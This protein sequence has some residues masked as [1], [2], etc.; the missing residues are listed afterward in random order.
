MLAIKCVA[1]RKWI[2]TCKP[3]KG[4]L[5][6]VT[7][8]QLAPNTR[9]VD[10]WWRDAGCSVSSTILTSNA[11]ARAPYTCITATG[12]VV[13]NFPGPLKFVPPV[14]SEADLDGRESE[15]DLDGRESEADLDGRESEADLD[16]RESEADLDGR[17]SEADLDGRESEAD[18]DGQKIE[19]DLND[20]KMECGLNSNKMEGGLNGK[21]WKVV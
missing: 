14:E 17:E 9:V 1:L 5:H 15:A 2:L 13:H 8:V 16:G 11:R 6:H 21:K 10:R 20:K 19:G 18:L 4:H 12:V 7:S 3:S